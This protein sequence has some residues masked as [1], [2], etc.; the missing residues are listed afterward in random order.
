[1]K[2]KWNWGY[3]IVLAM[4]CF[5]VFILQY[6]IRVQT[7]PALDN[8][9]ETEEYYQKEQQIN[10]NY[11]KETNGKTLGNKFAI[12]V[13]SEGLVISFPQDFKKESIK[14]KVVLKRLSDEKLDAEFPISLQESA[15]LIPKSQL[16]SGKWNVEVDWTYENEEYLHKQTVLIP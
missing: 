9:L 14:G 3:G 15:L 8:Q 1:M 2:F 6:V 5:I 10:S 11:K 16:V 4:F 12:E 7:N 13:V